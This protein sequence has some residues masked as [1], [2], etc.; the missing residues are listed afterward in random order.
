MD[1]LLNYDYPGN[2]RELENIIEHA[3][4][5]CR[6]EVIE[7]RHLPMYLQ[8]PISHLGEGLIS[9]TDVATAQHQWERERIIEVL[10]E[11]RWHRQGAAQALGMDRT[12]LWRKMKKYKISP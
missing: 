6:G 9:G 3:C 12:T 2:I 7:K 4:V 5:L 8:T 10:K 11:H 1:I